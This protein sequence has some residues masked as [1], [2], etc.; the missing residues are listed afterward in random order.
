VL[1][2]FPASFKDSPES[3]D[4]LE[5]LVRALGDYP[6]AVELRHRTWSDRI[7]RR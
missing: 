7:D 4:Y 3:R 2:Q 1:A 6:I 5:A